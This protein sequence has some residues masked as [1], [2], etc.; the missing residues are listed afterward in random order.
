MVDN[1]ANSPIIIYGAPRSG[2]TYLNRILNEHPGIAI[3][4]ET[5]LFTW[6]H[7]C[8]NRLT[9]DDK[10][11]LSYRTQFIDYL[12]HALPPMIR[13]FYRT[14]DPNARY[15]GDKNPHYLD[16]A[17]AECLDTIASLFPGTRFI[18]IIRDGRDVVASLVR[19]GWVGFHTAHR[20]WNTHVDR[21][22]TF[23]ASQPVECYFELRYEDLISADVD[24]ARTVFEFLRIDFHDNVARFC[25]AQRQ[26]RTPLSEPTRDLSSGAT[27]SDWTA[28]FDIDQQFESLTLLKQNLVRCGY[29]TELSL[30]H[31][32]ATVANARRCKQIREIIRVAL[33]SD[34]IVAI[35]SKGDEELV[36]LDG[37]AGWHFPQETDGVYAGYNP[38]NSAD[39]IR[40]LEIVRE[41]GATHLVIPATSHWWLEHYHQFARYLEERYRSLARL[42]DICTV[43]ELRS[44]VSPTTLSVM[45]AQSSA[46]ADKQSSAVV[47]FRC[48]ICGA[49]CE[50]AG[51]MIDRER[52]SCQA[53]GSTVRWRA[54]IHVLSKELFG[55]SIAL[56]DF[57]QASTVLGIGMTDWSGYADPLSTKFRYTN[58]FYHKEPNLDITRLPSEFE[59]K[60]DFVI[61][62]DVFEHVPPPVSIAFQNLRRLLKPTGVVVFTVPWGR[63]DK[64][65]EHFP[66]LYDYE[67]VQTNGRHVLKNTTRDGR[68]QIFEDLTF[69]GGPGATLEMRRF[70]DEALLQEF[71]QAGFS[72]VQ[73]HHEPCPNFGI[74]WKGNWSLPLSA[75]P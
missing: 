28:V 39:A 24:V 11:L 3:T 30:A 43:Y 5:R 9:Q 22:R 46:L 15:W 36:Q 68:T 67:I 8:L 66:D 52:R 64:T 58:T 73:I 57:P 16:E 31:N 41:K 48:N 27:R 10:A 40:H 75:R 44:A 54:V 55:A 63:G 21:G 47:R 34:S 53:C 38:G 60:F 65:V 70:T 13:D 6:L 69:H 23:G 4:H 37:P 7:R 18:H 61:S 2:T 14:V 51:D 56:P 72:S 45:H 29:E 32:I 62:S 59:E 74:Y 42:E 17:D 1:L 50:I 12:R 19:K 26:G 25:E 71:R 35:V 33:P 49:H 20:L